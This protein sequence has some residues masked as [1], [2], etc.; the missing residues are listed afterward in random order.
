MLSYDAR[1]HRRWRDYRTPGGARPVKS[2]LA[3]VTDEEVTSA[4]VVSKLEAG[5]DVKM[6]TLQR[7]CAAIGTAVPL[8]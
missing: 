7:C 8:R 3:K 1:H 5:G 4:S 2:F 6:S